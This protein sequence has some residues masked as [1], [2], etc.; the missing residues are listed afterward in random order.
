MSASQVT[1]R[2]GF[3]LMARRVAPEI[4]EIIDT[5]DHTVGENPF[6]RRTG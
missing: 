4:V 6:Y 1:L 3:E 5:A 2:Q